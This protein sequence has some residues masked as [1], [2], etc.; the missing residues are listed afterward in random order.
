MLVDD[1]RPRDRQS[2]TGAAAHRLR[3]EERLEDAVAQLVW[4]A[5]VPVASFGSGVGVIVIILG[6]IMQMGWLFWAGIALFGA[7]V[8]FQ[9]VNLPVEFDASRRAKAL[10]VER[11]IVPRED[12]AHVNNVLNAAHSARSILDTEPCTAR[13]AVPPSVAGAGG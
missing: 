13:F 12:M 5:A 11:G 9:L 1:H 10:L 6:A 7:V 2:L 3:G 4:N 8:F